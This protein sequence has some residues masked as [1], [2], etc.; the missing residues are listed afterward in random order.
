MKRVP[1]RCVEARSQPI[2]WD[3]IRVYRWLYWSFIGFKLGLYW[4]NGKGNGNCG[5]WYMGIYYWEILCSRRESIHETKP[6]TARERERGRDGVCSQA[7]SK[8]SSAGLAK[9]ETAPQ[10]LKCCSSWILLYDIR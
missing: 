9:D 3:Y 5:I 2:Y 7:S 6:Q 4:D 1:R 8:T 10:L